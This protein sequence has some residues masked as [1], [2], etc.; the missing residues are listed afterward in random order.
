M[1][2]LSKVIE[3]KRD[4]YMI[5]VLEEGTTELESL[6]TKKYLTE[7]LTLIGKILVE[8]GVVDAA[9]ANLANNWGKYAAGAGVVGAGAADQL[10]N[11]GAAANAVVQGAKDFGMG[12]ADKSANPPEAFTGP[13][14]LGVA[15]GNM[16]DDA[17]TIVHNGI[18]YIKD[19]VGN[20]IPQGD[21]P[22]PEAPAPEAQAP[23]APQS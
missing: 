20:L 8:E 1:A 16:A 23:Q 5:Q 11:D 4:E 10:L 9:K 13:M 2:L 12:F 18:T 22:A 21:A 7:N 19:A 6:K 3:N 17:G 14:S 15:T